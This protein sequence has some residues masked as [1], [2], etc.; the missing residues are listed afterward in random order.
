M[1]RK[2]ARKWQKIKKFILRI[3]IIG[4]LT[5]FTTIW[6]KM[7][8]ILEN[9]ET[10]INKPMFAENGL[11]YNIIILSIF[12]LMLLLGWPIYHWCKS[13][14]FMANFSTILIL[15]E[16]FGIIITFTLKNYDK[17]SFFLLIF[18]YSPLAYWILLLSIARSRVKKEAK[19]A[20]EAAL[21]RAYNSFQRV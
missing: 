21:S 20:N 10:V 8:L 3:L 4:L 11:E 15:A 2:T 1:N 17:G 6:V 16:I 18:S 5:F 13:N 9:A 12:S 14:D 19:E 7:F